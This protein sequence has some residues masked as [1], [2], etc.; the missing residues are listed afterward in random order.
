MKSLHFEM[1]LLDRA[2]ILLVEG[3]KYGKQRIGNEGSRKATR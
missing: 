3:E 1:C 2:I